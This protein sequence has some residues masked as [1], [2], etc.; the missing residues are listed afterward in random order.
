MKACGICR[1]LY[2]DICP[3]ADEICLE[4]RTEQGSEEGDHGDWAFC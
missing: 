1:T 4:C 2:P 3:N